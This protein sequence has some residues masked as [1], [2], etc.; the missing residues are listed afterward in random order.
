MKRF[1]TALMLCILLLSAVVPLPAFAAEQ[2]GFVPSAEQEGDMNEPPRTGDTIWYVPM[3]MS[4]ILVAGTA[5][6]YAIA[7]KKQRDL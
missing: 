6:L 1:L 7:D 2:D 5:V 4:G 3:A